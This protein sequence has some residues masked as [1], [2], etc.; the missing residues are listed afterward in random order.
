[1]GFSL[2]QRAKLVAT[3]PT[4]RSPEVRWT[5]RPAA[6]NWRPAPISPRRSKRPLRPQ[7][8]R[9]G[10]SRKSA[11]LPVAASA[12]WSIATIRAWTC[13][14][15]SLAGRRDGGFG[16]RLQPRVGHRLVVPF[17]SHHLRPPSTLRSGGCSFLSW[18]RCSQSP[19]IFASI[20][21]SSSSAEAVEI[22][23]RCGERMSLRWRPTWTRMRSIS[24]L[25]KSRSGM[26]RPAKC[27]APD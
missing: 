2:E 17:G 12:Y 4:M 23:A 13:W 21:P 16:Q 14:Y 11:R 7:P 22:P 15:T 27:D 8:M 20:L 19:S 10:L 5:M 24:A 6:L 26:V 25:T 3:G 1:M 18:S 9:W